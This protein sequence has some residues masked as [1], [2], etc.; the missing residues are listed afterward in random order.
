MPSYHYVDGDY[1]DE[2]E[3][4]KPRNWF[5]LDQDYYEKEKKLPTMTRLKK[6]AQRERWTSEFFGPQIHQD[7]ES[8]SSIER[9]IGIE[10]QNSRVPI[11]LPPSPR[12][13]DA[14]K[15]DHRWTRREGYIPF[16][17]AQ[18]KFSGGGS[19]D[20]PPGPSPPGPPPIY[21]H[22]YIEP[23]RQKGKGKKKVPR[24]PRDDPRN[25][26]LPPPR[27]LPRLQPM[28]L[29]LIPIPPRDSLRSYPIC[30]R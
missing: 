4:M 9:Q 12:D 10:A 26:P 15:Y 2:L 18:K 16:P 29:N 23:L 25:R 30:H 22:P 3:G 5:K 7:L 6:I 19:N 21:V 24:E 13:K 20:P 17:P 1:N 27:D 11:E 14:Y 8:L 28:P